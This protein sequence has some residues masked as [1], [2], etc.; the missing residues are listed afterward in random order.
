MKR[1]QA[2]KTNIKRY[3]KIQPEH[4]GYVQFGDNL[5]PD[6]RC[7]AEDCGMGVSKEWIYCPYCGQKLGKFREN[8]AAM[9]ETLRFDKEAANAGIREDIAGD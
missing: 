4:I 3:F 8:S 7:P 1:I 2:I 5:E 9:F 6:Y